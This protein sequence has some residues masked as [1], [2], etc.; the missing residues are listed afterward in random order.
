MDA[1][2]RLALLAVALCGCPVLTRCPE[3]CTRIADECG[4]AG[5][6][7]TCIEACH[8]LAPGDNNQVD[9]MGCVEA[10][11]CGD[12]ATG[13]CLGESLCSGGGL[14]AVASSCGIEGGVAVDG[15]CSAT[16]NGSWGSLG[17]PTVAEPIQYDS[18]VTFPGGDCALS[19]LGDEAECVVDG[20]SCLV[21]LRRV[22]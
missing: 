1:L 18:L 16:I 10:R 6:V 11:D 22:L 2:I 3:T 19:L 5:D 9:A 7:E 8:G 15:F 20:E 17:A 14:Y 21:V 13:E 4:L 12:I